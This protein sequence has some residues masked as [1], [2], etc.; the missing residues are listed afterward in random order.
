MNAQEKALDD[1]RAA[2]L[3]YPCFLHSVHVSRQRARDGPLV[4][5]M[6]A[7]GFEYERVLGFDSHRQYKIQRRNNSEAIPH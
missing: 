1:A 4:S 7:N 5:A 3:G 2:L 6:R